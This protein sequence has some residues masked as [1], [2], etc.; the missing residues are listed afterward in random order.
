VWRPRFDVDAVHY[1][2]VQGGS[3][4]F[5]A[6][7]KRRGLPLLISPVLWLTDENK[8]SMPLQ[9]IR[10]LLHLCDWVLPN[11]QAEKEQLAGFFGLDRGKVV[12]TCNGIDATFTTPA[13]PG[14]FRRRFGIEGPFLL[15]VANVEPRKNQL[16]LIEAIRGLGLDLVILGRARDEVYLEQCR[17]AG[18]GFV[19]YLGCV[20]HGSEL[21]KSAYRACAL[22]VLPSLLETPGLAALEAAALGAKL[23]VTRVGSTSEYFGTGATY[24][25]PLSV[26]DIRRGIVEEMNIQ[27]DE[28]LGRRVVSEFTW[29]RTAEQLLEAYEAARP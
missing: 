9:E 28:Q 22:F 13:D 17:R 18:D 16:R 3:M 21:L 15:N 4:N 11:S 2:S 25:E 26:A 6:H 12:V 27:R 24:V 5:C 7:V 23:V 10:D 1:F 29:N 8:W 19:R 14:L 20:E